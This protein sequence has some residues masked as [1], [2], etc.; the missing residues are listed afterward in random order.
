MAAYP[1]RRRAPVAW[2]TLLGTV[3]GIVV[4]SVATV[5]FLRAVEVTCHR[6]RTIDCTERETIL[7]YPVWSTTVEDIKIARFLNADSGP[8]GIFAETESGEQFRLTTSGL[9]ADVQQYLAN[10]IHQFIF[11]NRAETDLTLSRPPTL[12]YPLTGGLIVLLPL[13]YL[14]ISIVRL[15]IYFVRS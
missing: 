8:T 9:T 4:V 11:V 10:A 15:A 3:V 13:L 7:S 14:F 6:G 12:F 5:Y 2:G 1:A